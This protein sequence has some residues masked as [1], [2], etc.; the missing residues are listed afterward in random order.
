MDYSVLRILG[1]FSIAVTI[2]L[3]S[4]LAFRGD[5][6]AAKLLVYIGLILLS[7]ELL[8]GILLSFNIVVRV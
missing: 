8:S 1:Y 7:N 2:F 3:L 6:E 5:L 4:Y